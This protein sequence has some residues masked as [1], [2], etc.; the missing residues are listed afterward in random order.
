VTKTVAATSPA[1]P[2]TEYYL[3][4]IGT[5]VIVLGSSGI[6][7]STIIVAVE[8]L[9]GESGVRWET[10]SHSSM[11]ND[12][13]AGVYPLYGANCRLFKRHPNDPSATRFDLETARRWRVLGMLAS[14]STLA[15]YAHLGLLYTYHGITGSVSGTVS[16]SGGGTVNIDLFRDDTDDKVAAT[17]R[18]GNGSYSLTWY[19]NTVNVY[20]VAREDS[21]HLGRSDNDVMPLA[22]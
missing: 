5:E 18:V 10:I 15:F 11:I 16:G 9:A 22:A 3:S 7:A 19:D 2:E 14:T 17:S 6:S 12:N 1:L 20:T 4:N 8:R 21:T 13:E